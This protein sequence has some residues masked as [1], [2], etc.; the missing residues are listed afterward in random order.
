M[1]RKNNM[2][3]VC[4]SHGICHHIIGPRLYICW[5]EPRSGPSLGPEFWDPWGG[6]IGFQKQQYMTR[7]RRKPGGTRSDA[8]ILCSW[9]LQAMVARMRILRFSMSRGVIQYVRLSDWLVRLKKGFATRERY[10]LCFNAPCG[11]GAANPVRWCDLPTWNKR[12]DNGFSKIKDQFWA[13]ES[14]HYLLHDNFLWMG[15]TVSLSFS[16]PDWQMSSFALS[17]SSSDCSLWN[18]SAHL[19]H[20]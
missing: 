20:R 11:F 13:R 16:W 1:A 17:W 8:P 14:V 10:V 7:S 3:F 18:F 4:I 5:I 9:E 2:Y 12:T 15:V 19:T 6:A